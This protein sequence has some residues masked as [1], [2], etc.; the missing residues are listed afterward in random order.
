LSFIFWFHPYTYIYLW[1]LWLHA[2]S[3]S[4]Q[5]LRTSYRLCVRSLI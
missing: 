3:L 1:S 5:F 2:T 4:A